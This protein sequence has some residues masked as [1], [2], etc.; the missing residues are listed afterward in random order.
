MKTILIGYADER[1]Q[2]VPV[3]VAGPEVSSVAQSLTMA[4]AKQSQ[5]FPDGVVRLELCPVESVEI[6]IAINPTQPKT[7]KKN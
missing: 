3:I 2:S 5:I 7:K 6:A 1:A 4:R